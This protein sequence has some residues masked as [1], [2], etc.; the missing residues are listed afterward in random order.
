MNRRTCAC[1][2]VIVCAELDGYDVWLDQHPHGWITLDAQGHATVGAGTWRRH[3][4]AHDPRPIDLDSPPARSGLNRDRFQHAARRDLAAAH[5]VLNSGRPLSTIQRRA[6]ELRAG[7]P[8][9]SYRQ[10]AHNAGVTLAALSTALQGVR[11]HADL[12]TRTTP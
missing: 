1:E 2:A 3:T 12:I 8:N 9:L 11:R 5:A 7:N 10:L 6:A 4:C